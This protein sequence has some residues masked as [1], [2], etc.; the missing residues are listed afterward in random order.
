MA[1]SRGTGSISTQSLLMPAT[2]ASMRSPA[3][4]PRIASAALRRSA[5]CGAEPLLGD[6]QFLEVE[7]AA[8]VGDQ[9]DALELVGDDEEAKLLAQGFLLAVGGEVAGECRGAAGDGEPVVAGQ[10]ELF[11]EELIELLVVAAVGAVDRGS[12]DAF[13]GERGGMS[14][15]CA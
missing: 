4:R 7:P 10:A 6:V 1:Q 11:V 14:A 8:L 12:A 2:K 5:S 3:F 15:R 9:D 13:M